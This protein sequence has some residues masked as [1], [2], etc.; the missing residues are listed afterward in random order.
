MLRVELIGI[1]IDRLAQKPARQQPLTTVR[2]GFPPETFEESK[3][4]WCNLAYIVENF[5]P[6]WKQN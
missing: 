5:L 6:K 2:I 4:F 1:F 3:L